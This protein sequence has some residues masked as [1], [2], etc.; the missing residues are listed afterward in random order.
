MTEHM[1]EPTKIDAAASKACTQSGAFALLL[2]LG[3]F[4][5]IP[6]WIE[7]PREV[8]L[9]Q[10]IAYRDSMSTEL[11]MLD[12]DLAWSKYKNQNPSAESMSIADLSR[13]MVEMDSQ[14][15]R[16]QPTSSLSGPASN[17][18]GGSIAAQWH[19]TPPSNLTATTYTH[20][21]EIPP[22][23]DFLSKLNDPRLLSD[24]ARESNF[25]N[26]SIFRWVQRRDTLM[27]GNYF[28]T[29]CGQNLQS[30][31]IGVNSGS[32]EFSIPQLD[33]DAM[34]GCLT[35]NDVREL[36]AFELPTAPS[37]LQVNGRI[38]RDVN[39][40][41][42]AL[43]QDLYVASLVVELLLFFVL[44]YFNA[45]AREAVLSP[46]FPASGTLF[47]AF[48]RSSWTLLMMWFV[49]WVPLLA[50]GTMSIVSR[51]PLLLAFNLPIFVVVFSTHR[52]LRRGL[53]HIAW[54]KSFHPPKPPPE[55][56]GKKKH[57]P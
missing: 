13:V 24:A 33:R 23:S 38:L 16:T 45:F 9:S 14:P 48:G 18:G 47:G 57:R 12:D 8:A 22:I 43:P 41:P 51:R 49:L 46:L 37:P 2:S 55:E 10:Y 15:V 54:P 27:F 40:T 20:L 28:H 19:L 31:N 6:Y 17:S 56:P 39:L 26:Y 30:P 5:L 34:L 11:D 44:G 7:R 25:F 4:L 32:D 50:S 52:L 42:G 21:D 35:L 36:A 1:P 53:P 29:S 3:L